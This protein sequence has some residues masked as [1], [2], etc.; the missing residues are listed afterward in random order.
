MTDLFAG[1]DQ[2]SVDLLGATLW[3]GW[4]AAS[5]QKALVADLRDVAK[6]APFQ[7]YETPSGARMSVQMTA[8]GD[9]GWMTDR[10][11]YRYAER[12]I[13]GASWPDIPEAILNIWRA[14]SGAARDP[15]SCLV[16]FYG[17][18][19]RMGL[20]Q[21]RD[22][23]NTTWPVVSISLGDDGLFRIGGQNRGD[24]TVS[25]WLKSGDVL[26]LSGAARLAYHG[27]DRIRFGSSGL[28][29]DGGR[30]NI[31]LRVAQ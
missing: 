27:I 5:A 25:H 2:P 18:G 11:G 16:N 23:A 10:S 14:T 8:A 19:A 24:P 1:T 9:V 17:E 13:S 31:T 4:L 3:P 12:H 22:E 7:R 6:R 26:V 21:D 28:L 29:P 20:H 15:D 30:L